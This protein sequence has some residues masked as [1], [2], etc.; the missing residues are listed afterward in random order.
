MAQEI[1]NDNRNQQESWPATI[2]GA[3]FFLLAGLELMAGDIPRTWSIPNRLAGVDFL[4]L[5][6]L[7]V[8]AIAFAIGWVFYFP[9]WSYPYTAALPV[10]SLYMMST[11]TPL[12]RQLGYLNRGWGYLAW[13]PFLLA[14]LVGLLLTRSLHPI[15]RFFTNIRQDWTLGTYAMFAWMPMLI[16]IGFDEIYRL[17]SLVFKLVLT[18]LMV[19]TSLL[20]LR[21]GRHKSQSRIMVAGVL[22]SLAVTN[23]GSIAYWQPVGG[24]FI[25]GAIAW[26]LVIL[27]VM[28]SPALILRRGQ[29]TGGRSAQA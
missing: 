20:Y 1:L 9:R 18:I 29:S 15:A 13:I 2:A 26:D 14:V 28:F 5:F 8:P 24:V 23:I 12:L 21:A 11:A 7:L 19:A 10:F 27:G 17:Y 16:S 3:L 6:G 25:P 22:I 4:F